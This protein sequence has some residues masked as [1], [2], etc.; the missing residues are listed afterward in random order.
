MGGKTFADAVMC[1][2]NGRRTEAEDV[3]R[4][5][6]ADDGTLVEPHR[7]LAEILA[8][9]GRTEAALAACRRVADLAPTDELIWQRMGG[10]LLSLGRAQEALAAF[11]QA[12]SRAPSFA[13]AH[14]GRGMTLIGFGRDAE[15]AEA[16]ARAVQIDPK[17]AA[18]MMLQAGYQM[19]QLGR[20]DAALATFARLTELQP[21][22]L[23]ARNAHAMALVTMGRFAQVAPELAALLR[24][25]PSADYLAGISLHAKL[26]CCDWEG[27][28]E[29]SATITQRVR[30]GERADAPLTF[31]VHNGSPADQL[32]CARTYA[33]HKCAADAPALSSAPRA[34]SQRLRIAY[35]S[36]DFRDHAVSQCL[37]EVLEAHDRTRIET[38]AF[39]TGPDDGSSLRRRIECGVEHFLQ[40]AALSDRDIAARM[41]LLAIDIAVDL[42]GHSAGG[43]T[44]VLAFRAAP[45]Q[46]SFLGFP[47]TTGTN[48]VDY[49]IADERVLPEAQQVHYSEQAV[50]L[51]DTCFPTPRRPDFLLPTRAQAGLP[52][53]GFVYCAFNG[54]HKISPHMFALWLRVLRA[55]PDSVLWL[56]SASG[57]VCDNLAQRA[58]QS[59]VARGRLIFAERTATRVDHL[60]RFAL[61]DVFLDTYPYGAHTTASEALLGGVPVITLKGAAFASRVAFSLLCACGLE[62]LAVDSAEHY[63]ALAVD[64]GLHPH[65]ALELKRELMNRLPGSGLFAPQRFSRQLETAYMHMHERRLKGERPS[66]LRISPDRAPENKKGAL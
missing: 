26:Q 48:Y 11:D 62:P 57:V 55:V 21:D 16:L 31:I 35:L 24:A 14:A 2:R 50:Y 59:G 53:T 46:V 61:A 22:S 32:T 60:A 41:A 23:E 19:L 42:G 8:S 52:P 43:R 25:D 45:V 29:D 12:I 15:A 1:W 5:L 9:S 56:R 47:G 27:F 17:G 63:Q 65:K 44:R 37:V 28:D 49:L 33:A 36:A 4:A 3:C 54:P 18:P 40:V 7:L 58:E 30:H 34:N 13:R 64:L 39:S 6:I 51:P 20:P 10:L 66:P 38:Y